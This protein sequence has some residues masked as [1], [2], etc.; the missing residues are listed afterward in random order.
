MAQ[1]QQEYQVYIN[2]YLAAIANALEIT[3]NYTSRGV[4]RVGDTGNTIKHRINKL[5]DGQEF[6]LTLDYDRDESGAQAELYSNIGSDVS[7]S[8]TYDDTPLPS[9]YTEATELS[10]LCE[11]SNRI[12]ITKYSSSA[13][14]SLIVINKDNY[15][16]VTSEEFTLTGM[17]NIQGAWSDG[18]TIYIV[19]S[20][21]ST[22]K[23][24]AFNLASKARTSSL[25][26]SLAIV[27]LDYRGL[28]SDGTTIWTV[29]PTLVSGKYVAKAFTISSK[30]ANTS[31]DITLTSAL[32]DG[33]TIND[34]IL[35]T[36][37]TNSATLL[38][39]N[40]TSGAAITSSNIELA[41][42]V[43]NS[44][45]RG[46][47]IQNRTIYAIE[48]ISSASS[49][50]EYNMDGSRRD[51]GQYFEALVV[52]ANFIPSD[53]NDAEGLDQI[54]YNLKINSDITNR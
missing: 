30:A 19:G 8:V 1:R 34:S 33:L 29:S 3:D 43:A 49:V 28:A 16:R 22:K 39:Y 18:T 48:H 6:S 44:V 53:A 13:N 51:K 42:I 12:Y 45:L 25:D 46:I 9:I 32:P 4:R 31:N 23:I 54:T 27:S 20:I 50:Y 17:R 41:D 38:A 52:N 5:K 36:S 2:N 40:V 26:I 21:S 35:Y 14:T 7:V 11:T 15:A 37:Y 24:Y 47:T 10:G